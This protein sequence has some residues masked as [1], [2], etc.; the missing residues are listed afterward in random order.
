MFC[1]VY[2]THI[3]DGG[4]YMKSSF[5]INEFKQLKEKDIPYVIPDR[6]RSLVRHIEE[7]LSD[8]MNKLKAA[9]T[10]KEKNEIKLKTIINAQFVLTPEDRK[11]ITTIYKEAGFKVKHVET[12]KEDPYEDGIRNV[13]LPRIKYSQ[14]ILS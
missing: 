4:Y 3:I 6:V 10:N 11:Y 7:T 9:K 12:S 8:K 1:L 5:N 2:L 13:N 14:I